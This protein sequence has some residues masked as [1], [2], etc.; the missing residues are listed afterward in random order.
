LALRKI[1]LAIEIVRIVDVMILR[2][3]HGI[4]NIDIIGRN[5]IAGILINLIFSV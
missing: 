1:A 2:N 4:R 3:I 5:R